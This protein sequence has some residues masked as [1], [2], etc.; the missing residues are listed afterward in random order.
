MGKKAY[1]DLEHNY[2]KMPGFL[3]D[4]TAEYV[5]TP[6]SDGGYWARD[7]LQFIA[8]KKMHIYVL[9][10]DKV[11]R[12]EFLLQDYKDTNEN[13]EVGKVVMS[14]FHRV[15]EEGESIIMAGNSNKDIPDGARMYTVI[16]KPFK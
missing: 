9:H 13:I 6:N 1:T 10:D 4:V 7:Q 15:A 14:I 5:R 12:P 3:R 2:T 11:S 16:A 8:G